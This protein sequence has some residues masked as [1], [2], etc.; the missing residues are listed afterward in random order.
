MGE[1]IWV[2]IVDGGG[3]CMYIYICMYAYMNEYII[4]IAL[5]TNIISYKSTYS[6]HTSSQRNER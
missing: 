4:Y 1:N 2:C 3:V 6:L 5:H